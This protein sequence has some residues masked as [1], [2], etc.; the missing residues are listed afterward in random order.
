MQRIS[1]KS[2]HAGR[3]QTG[4]KEV[5]HLTLSHLPFGTKYNVLLIQTMFFVPN[6]V[7]T[8]LGFDYFIVTHELVSSIKREMYL[9]YLFPSPSFTELQL[10]DSTVYAV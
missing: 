6:M 9:I 5:L 7:F 4:S 2:I 1:L 3:P 8:L 10:T